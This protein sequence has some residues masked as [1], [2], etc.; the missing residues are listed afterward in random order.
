AIDA[1]PAKLQQVEDRLALLER[2]KR[3][4]GGTLDAV[5]ARRDALRREQSDLERGD[6]RLAD[7]ERELTGARSAYV[8]AAEA[9][10]AVRRRAATA[11]SKRLVELLAELAMDRTRFEVRFGAPLPEDD[12]SARGVDA[13]EFFLS[14]NPGEDLRPLAKIVSGGE[15]SRVMLAIKTL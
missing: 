9:L 15:L 14:P 12:W 1:S 11:L 2:L 4:H 7:L 8:E 3:K 10:S 5:I 6:E 13:A